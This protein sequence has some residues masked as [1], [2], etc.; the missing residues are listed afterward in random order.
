M[1]MPTVI[2]ANQT[3]GNIL[4]TR[5]G[6]TVPASS[7]L[8]LTD[9]CTVNEIREDESLEAQIAAGNIL[10]NYGEG[11][12]T[13]GDS[14]KFFD[15]Q[16]LESRIP[17]R[18]M[19]STNI[20][21]LSG[22]T[23]VDTTVNLNVN[24]RVLLQGQTT[25]TQNGIWVVQAGAWVRPQ[26]FEVGR[27][28]AGAKVF[29]EEGTLYAG[30][31]WICRALT[32]SDV[33]GTNNL[34]FSQISGGGGGVTNLQEAYEGGNT[35]NVTAAE[36]PLAFTLTSDNFTVDGANDFLIG[37]TTPLANFTVDAGVISLDSTDDSNL[38]MTANAAG[39][40]TLSITATN[41]G[42]GD[43]LIA[44]S[45]DG[46]TDIDAGGALSLNS[47]GGAINI[48]NDAV[49]QPI[50]IGT[51]A[52]ARTVT[53]GN[54]TGAT[55]LDLNSGT[56]GTLLDSTGIIS[57]DG[58]GSSNFTTT[59][60]DLTLQT[61]TTGGINVNAVDGMSI[62]AGS[63]I[64]MNS[65]GGNI[66]IGN[67]AD[68]G[69]IN[70]GTAASARD[71]TIGNTTGAT[72]LTLQTGSGNTL[73]DS[74][75]VTMT[76]NLWVQG[77][78][79]TVQSEIVNIAD[80][81]LYLNDG[82]T[83][84][85][86]LEGG[87]I[88][89]SLPT[90]TVD[91]VAGSFISGTTALA[92]IAGT[93]SGTSGTT[94]LTGVGTAFTTELKV[95]WTIVIDPGGVNETKV[96]ASITSDTVLDVTTNLA[97]NHAGVTVDRPAQNAYVTTTGAA[98]FA[99]GDYIQ[100]SGAN[101]QTNDG[102]YEVLSHAGTKLSIKGI[103][104]TAPAY[105]FV[106]N[107][108][109][110]DT[111]VQGAITKVTVGVMQV[112]TAGN[113]QYGY[114]ST[115][116]A[117]T[118]ENVLVTSDLTLQNAYVGGN[119]ITTSAG[120]GNVVIAGTE[121]LN[122]T[123]TGGLNLDTVFDADVTTFDVLMTGN[124]GFSIDGTASSNVTATNT[125]ATTNVTLTLEAT[126]TGATSGNAL[127]DINA[128]STNGTGT[129]ELDA[130]DTVAVNVLSG[131]AINIGTDAVAST[132]TIGN[133]T[134]ASAVI[135]NSGTELVQVDG[136]TYYGTSAGLPTPRAGG[137]QD[138]DK[139]YDT[140]LDMEMRYDATRAKWLSVEAMI[141][142][143]GRQGNNAA[144]TY[145]RAIDGQVMSSTQGWY[146]PHN[147]T[148]VALGYTRSDSDA[149]TF[150]VVEG[151]TSRATLASAATSGVSTSLDG[152]F[153]AGGILAVLNQAGGNTTTNVIAWVKVRFR[154]V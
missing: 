94:T 72:S 19:S 150:D 87:I 40:K 63:D 46:A 117:L 79:T 53:I 35:I 44:M 76:G 24:D 121:Q 82:Y 9:F 64:D 45:S 118:F 93:V 111:V 16:T 149:A 77:T 124:N 32:G 8:T 31:M 37:G 7:T 120:E 38:T 69:Q 131:G 5:M 133:N 138:G 90:T 62:D 81:F 39:N 143:F 57:L 128:T 148:I 17:V 55:Q 110:D 139:F 97:N 28:A 50:N 100:V 70:V 80:S 75:L 52:A 106:Q 99:A 92:P 130:D 119:T 25:P 147:G 20:A 66:N 10:L 36:G 122:V 22:T 151:G 3:A 34:T 23:T 11:N 60:G 136:V 51:G 154:S 6:L 152:N 135:I 18:G 113:F 21:S 89:N 107:Q 65:S 1:A 71:I 30:T 12:L 127:V 116:G 42:A 145:Y 104:L 108:F 54:A 140:N 84:N 33:I 109:V 129:I 4:L 48:G 78:T 73:I 26:D 14:L 125:V 98:T 86:G 2:A 83:T 85:S 43:G 96:I 41:A 137:F 74:P 68:T 91:T 15:I 126:N 47:S 134:G 67:A 103:G 114:S 132:T 146:M 88:V 58:V 142:H 105:N 95:G 49:A 123:A 27:S 13:Q 144:A 29:V 102:L 141:C 153:S 61:L 115:S 101:D 59:S 112:D 56:G